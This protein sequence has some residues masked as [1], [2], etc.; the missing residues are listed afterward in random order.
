MPRENCGLIFTPTC[1]LHWRAGRA[2]APRAACIPPAASPLK[3]IFTS[4]PKQ[5]IC[6]VSSAPIL[7]PPPA[8]NASPQATQESPARSIQ[9]QAIFCFSAMSFRNWTPRN[10][11]AWQPC[12]SSVRATNPF[13]AATDTARSR[14]LTRFN[15]SG[16]N[17]TLIETFSSAFASVFR[18]ICFSA[19]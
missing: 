13:P 3:R 6:R 15:Y 5:A 8:R 16:I 18:A 11:Q 1:R 2:A 10:Q 7:T 12:W 17:S 4:T 14:A 9:R 19:F